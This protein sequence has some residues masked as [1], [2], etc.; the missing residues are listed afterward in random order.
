MG[1]SFRQIFRTG[2]RQ[3]LRTRRLLQRLLRPSHA[4]SIGTGS[5]L[6]RVEVRRQGLL[7]TPLGMR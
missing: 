6:L 5:R 2:G 1:E 4:T 7:P 3:L